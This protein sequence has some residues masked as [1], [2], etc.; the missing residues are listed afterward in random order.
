LQ[1]E[2]ISEAGIDPSDQMVFVSTVQEEG[3]IEAVF[4]LLNGNTPGISPP[5]WAGVVESSTMEQLWSQVLGD[6][7]V[8]TPSGTIRLQQGSSSPMVFK[9]YRIP[10]AQDRFK[11]SLARG[12][13]RKVPEGPDNL[14]RRAEWFRRRAGPPR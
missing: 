8:S 12:P 4:S 14:R 9:L 6:L 7:G 10:P 2:G 13:A 3:F 5:C 1:V 11:E